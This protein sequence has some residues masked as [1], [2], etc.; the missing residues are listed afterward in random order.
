[1]AITQTATLET[2]AETSEMDV[3]ALIEAMEEK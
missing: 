2:N 1:M 3:V